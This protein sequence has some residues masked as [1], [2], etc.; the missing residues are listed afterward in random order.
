[1]TRDLAGNASVVSEMHL[2]TQPRS[3][4]PTRGVI[5]VA[6]LRHRVPKEA[7]KSFK[8]GK[9]FSGKGDHQNAARELENA[10]ARD[11]EYA[12]AH[13][14]L[15]VEYAELGRAAEAEAELRRAIALDPYSWL[16]HHDL[17][18]MLI[19]IGNFA[20]AGP[21]ARRALELSPGN[22]EARFLV[23]W[24]LSMSA[25]TRAEGRGYLEAAAR[26]LPR[27]KSVLQTLDR[28]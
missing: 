14:Q 2:T 13:H 26:T 17:G 22:D 16:A 20:E 3:T 23:G 21:S 8:R 4:V 11:P 10:V 19:R 6:Q 24:L 12:D 7:Q 5:S 27:A 9:K 18:V 1:M 28:K 15:G 25:D